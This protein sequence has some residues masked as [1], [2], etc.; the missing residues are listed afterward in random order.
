MKKLRPISEDIFC[1]PTEDN[2]IEVADTFP[3]MRYSK[4]DEDESSSAL[5]RTREESKVPYQM[6]C[7]WGGSRREVSNSLL[8]EITF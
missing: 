5:N 1:L 2:P 7:T 3:F 4:E 6:R 8:T